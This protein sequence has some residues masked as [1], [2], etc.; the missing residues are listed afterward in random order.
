METK[1]LGEDYFSKEGIKEELNQ[2]Y[3]NYGGELSSEQ[4]DQLVEMTY[5]LRNR[6]KGALFQARTIGRGS[7]RKKSS[8]KRQVPVSV[9]CASNYSRKKAKPKLSVIDVN[10][11]KFSKLVQE[12]YNSGQSVY[13]DFNFSKE[14][15]YGGQDF[16]YKQK[17]SLFK[18]VK[19]IK[20]LYS[21]ILSF[22]NQKES[23]NN[24]K[25]SLEYFAG[26]GSIAKL[27]DFK[28]V[29]KG[30]EGK[31]EIY[32]SPIRGSDHSPNSSDQL[33]LNI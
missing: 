18:P 23:I 10:R 25:D 29:G 30:L 21:D 3:K 6:W 9:D 31:F 5:E 19:N 11:D 24:L 2:R 16:K 17:I 20:Y 33:S 7:E 4:F 22:E 26:K 8:L 12:V 28:E 27:S 13:G 1:T 14:Y 15:N 32:H